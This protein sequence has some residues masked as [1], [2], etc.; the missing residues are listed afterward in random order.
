M[1]IFTGIGSSTKHILMMISMLRHER[2]AKQI[3]IYEYETIQLCWGY[4]VN[5]YEKF[6]TLYDLI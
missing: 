1:S 4:R 3:Y 5:V 2:N 6:P